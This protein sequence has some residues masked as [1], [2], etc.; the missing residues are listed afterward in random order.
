MPRHTDTHESAGQQDQ[1]NATR[2]ATHLAGLLAHHNIPADVHALP[3]GRVVVSVFA[4]LV[5]HVTASHIWWHVPDLTGKRTRPLTAYAH[6]AEAAAV[7][8]ARLY[9]DMRAMPLA[10]LLSTGAIRPLAAA[11]L[12]DTPRDAAPL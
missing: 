4:G 2:T 9:T 6:T 7:R 11:L 8:L 10:D 1:E 5:A 3:H 12:D